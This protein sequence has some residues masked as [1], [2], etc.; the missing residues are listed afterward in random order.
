LERLTS[1]LRSEVTEV[2]GDAASVG[3]F[4]LVHGSGSI[5]EFMSKTRRSQRA[6]GMGAC[7]LSLFVISGCQRNTGSTVANAQLSTAYQVVLLVNG[8]SYIGKLE[9]LGT[10]FPVLTDVYYIQS[11][12]KQ[13]SKEVVNTLVKRGKEWHAPDRML[14]N[15]NQIVFVEPV[16]AGSQV[17]QLIEQQKKE[18][19]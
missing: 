18:K 13:D 8:Q 10:A 5:S 12:V 16:T 9:G 6:L 7:I 1:R 14:I 2:L 19:R 15:A 17:A 11:G 4:T 3:L